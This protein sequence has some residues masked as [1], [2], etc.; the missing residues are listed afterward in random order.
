MADAASPPNDLPAAC[1]AHLRKA[2]EALRPGDLTALNRSG[3]ILNA[4]GQEMLTQLVRDFLEMLDTSA[5]VYEANGD[6]AL[7]IFASDWC[8][9]MDQ[10]SR[11][12][13]QTDDNQE[14]LDSRKWISHESC[15]V[16]ASKR[17]ME[18][19]APVDIA[20]QGGI[21]VYAVPIFASRAVVGAINAGY[22]APPRDQ[23][24]LESLAAQ[25]QTPVEQLRALAERYESRPPYIIELARQ[26]VES[27]ARLIGE[28]V[29]R[30]QAEEALRQSETQLRSIFRAAP[31]GIGLA[32]NRVL[33]TANRHLGEITGY[34]REE[35]IGMPAQQIYGSPAEYERVG[36]LVEAQIAQRGAASVQTRFRRKDNTV[37][38]VLLN[39][40]L[41]DP[42]DPSRGKTFTAMDISQRRQ[43]ETAVRK[44]EELYR[45]LV[46]GLP[47]VVQHLDREGRHIF[48]SE[49]IAQATGR[50]AREFV[51]KTH[52]EMGF[53]EEECRFWDQAL[54]RVVRTGRPYEAER[55]AQGEQGAKAFNVRLA[56]ERDPQGAVQSVLAISRDI[57][58]QRQA[59]QDYRTLFQE[60]LN[61]FAV[62]DI[63]CDEHGTPVDYRFLAVNPAFERMVGLKA[64]EVVGKTVLEVLPGTEPHWIS[65]YGKVGLTGEPAAFENYA[66][67]LQ[68][69]FEVTA[70]RPAPNQCAVI[71]ADITERK[72]AE[73]VVRESEE[74]F[75]LLVESAP[76]AVYVQANGRFA[77]VNDAAVHLL[78]AES[79]EQLLGQPILERTHPDDHDMVQQ[80]IRQTNEGRQGT[81]TSEQRY[82]R[83]DGAAVEAEVSAAPIT[84]CGQNGAIVF[85]RD[86]AERKQ[87]Q[88]M[89]WQTKM[90]VEHSPVVLFRWRNAPG[91]PVEFVSENVSQF[92]YSPEALVRQ[93]TPF[94]SLIHPDDLE[95]VKADMEGFTSAGVEDFRKEYRLL[96]KDGKVRWVEERAVAVRDL[97]GEVLYFNGVVTDISDRK[98][99]EAQFLQAQKM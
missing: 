2:L 85:V 57:T 31:V 34:S 42:D 69:H 22:G 35:I 36:R 4:V 86:I 21:H 28:I 3:L 64:D 63:I 9:F 60:M 89:L 50:P 56:P 38:D 95:K 74:R 47:D 73:D 16:E 20:C 39:S 30:S 90:V 91:M 54:A 81:H 46:E 25:Y 33:W 49:N 52:R 88:E 84:Y 5:A 80:R 66:A 87:M 71:F 62:H 65:T 11:R 44:G 51:G 61:G 7:G 32:V 40:A 48:A 77:Y 12:L 70:F 75:R 76:D 53:P 27:S 17:C 19:G 26:R 14:A 99:M 78:G 6:Y 1:T 29:S 41:L 92:G 83:L 68:K 55:T 10:R 93:R 98:Q 67:V 8:R 13:C 23:E 79:A 97:A 58:A 72:Q 45:T 18:T 96:G 94:A 82:L 37:V 24:T 43:M 59:E 15:W